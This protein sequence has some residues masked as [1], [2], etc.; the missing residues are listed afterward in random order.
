M[1]E[2]PSSE[3][4]TAELHS[5]IMATNGHDVSKYYMALG[6]VCVLKSPEVNVSVYSVYDIIMTVHSLA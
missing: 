2:G 5:C 6:H 3:T 1:S 4:P